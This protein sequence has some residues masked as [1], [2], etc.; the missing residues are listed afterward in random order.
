MRHTVTQSIY[1]QIDI[2]IIMEE[3]TRSVVK[4]G[5][6]NAVV[7]PVKWVRHFN[8]SK[9]SSVF[10]RVTNDG[11]LV[12]RGPTDKWESDFLISKPTGREKE[13]IWQG[14]FSI[15][16]YICIPSGMIIKSNDGV[17]TVTLDVH[18]DVAAVKELEKSVIKF[19]SGYVV[20]LPNSWVRY[21]ELSNTDKILMGIN[22]D[23]ELIIKVLDVK[24]RFNIEMEKQRQKKEIREKS[25]R[26]GKGLNIEIDKPML[27]RRT[28]AKDQIEIK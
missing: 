16:S 27:I 3:K 2:E 12:V 15:Q 24:K 7:L 4:L 26:V 19:G 13:K 9:G 1:H 11:N 6:G 25:N 10:M 5:E 21:F 23:M 20:A 22:S 18:N 17:S 8:I 28:Y 14:D